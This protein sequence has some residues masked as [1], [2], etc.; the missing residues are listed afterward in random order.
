MN[1]SMIIY[2]LGWILSCEGI[3]ILPSYIVALVYGE[4][5]AGNCL[6]IAAALCL[7][8]GFPITRKKPSDS[9]FYTK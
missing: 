4:F 5:A 9:V 8:L 1:Y 7:I 2:I 3:L 6:L